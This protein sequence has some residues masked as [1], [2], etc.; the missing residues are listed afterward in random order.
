[1][2]KNLSDGSSKPG[3]FFVLIAQHE[4]VWHLKIPSKFLQW[5]FAYLHTGGIAEL[6]KKIA[7][8]TVK[9]DFCKVIIRLLQEEK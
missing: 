2:T 7:D 1:M 9:V 8:D 6:I 3:T 4:E 5:N